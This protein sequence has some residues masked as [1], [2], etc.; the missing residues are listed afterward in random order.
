MEAATRPFWGK[1]CMI[2]LISFVLSV[3]TLSLIAQGDWQSFKDEV[4]VKIENISGW[5]SPEKA[6]LMMDLIKEKQLRYCVEIGTFSG[7]SL[8]PIIKTLQY[9]GAGYAFGIDAW[10]AQEAIKGFNVN[11]PNHAWWNSLDYEHFYRQ[12]ILLLN[13]NKLNQYGSLV[14][15]TS[16]TAIHLF[17]DETIDFIHFDGSKNETTLYQDATTY[18]FKVKNGGYILLNDPNSWSMKKTLVFLLERTEL[19]SSFSSSASYFLFRK[20]EQRSKN[21]QKLISS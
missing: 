1:N 15:Q 17:E 13:Q 12:A 16:Q 19:I 8:F 14:R 3:T 10:S 7:K 11:D 2:K 5:C 21:A 4:V 6:G 18:F 20:D 9:N